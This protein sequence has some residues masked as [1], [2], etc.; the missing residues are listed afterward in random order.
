MKASCE[1]RVR[2]SVAVISLL[3]SP[4]VAVRCWTIQINMWQWNYVDEV[5]Q[6][7]LAVFQA[8]S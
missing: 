2:R 4:K 6:V 1:K 7:I 5:V 8:G 3:V